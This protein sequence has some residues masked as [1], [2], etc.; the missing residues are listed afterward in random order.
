ML[1][2][3]VLIAT[4]ATAYANCCSFDHSMRIR[5]E[6]NYFTVSLARLFCLAACRKIMVDLAYRPDSLCCMVTAKPLTLSSSH[7]SS[8]GETQP[9]H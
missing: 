1:F 2:G 3:I 8:Q 5:P 9:Y 4:A 6:K 7:R